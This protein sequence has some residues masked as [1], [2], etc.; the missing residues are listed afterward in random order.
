MASDDRTM[1]LPSNP[2][3]SDDAVI[4]DLPPQEG[5][6]DGEGG[7]RTARE[8]LKKTS[9]AGLS[10][11]TKEDKPAG[12]HPLGEVVNADTIPDAPP[13]NGQARGRPSK[14]RS[15]DDLQNEEAAFGVENGGPPLPKK[16]TVHKRMR[17]RELSTDVEEAHALPKNDDIVLSVQ[18]ETGTDAQKSPGGPGVL[19]SPPSKEEMNTAT[20]TDPA[21]TVP[22]V[23]SS[24]EPKPTT[25][26]PTSAVSVAADKESEPKILATSG[27]ANTSTASPFSSF[28]SP[29][30][31]EKKLESAP[32]SPGAAASTSAFASSGLS[33]FAGSEKSPFGTVGI[34]AKSSGGFGSSSTSRG[35]GSNSSGFGGASPFATKPAS[36]FGAG[37]GFGSNS[38]FGGAGGFGAAPKP[39]AGGLSSFAGPSGSTGTFAKSKPFGAKAND[40]DDEASD[41][42]GEDGEGVE[43][44]EEDLDQDQDPRFHQQ[45]GE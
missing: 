4:H 13:E 17:S 27:F 32:L 37:G 34:T 44:T 21:D 43:Q 19:V 8:K 45:E 2:T 7:E 11:Q 38:G 28:A 16:G 22:N 41:D 14:K 9:I 10:Q 30:S 18:E 26:D 42:G 5:S 24:S 40:D 1:D 6:S 39:F 20:K 35:F 3:T 15:F 31:P 23:T 33:A 29:R 36:G 25:S 12:D